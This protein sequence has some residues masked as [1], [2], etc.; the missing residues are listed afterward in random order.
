MKK[1]VA[2]FLALAMLLSMGVVAVADDAEKPVITYW[3]DLGAA[4]STLT[5][6]AGSAREMW[7][8]I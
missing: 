6:I 3:C 2:V 5:S 8:I 7:F 4:S 1:M